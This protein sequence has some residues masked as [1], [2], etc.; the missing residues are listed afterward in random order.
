MSRNKTGNPIGSSAFL[1]FEDNVKNL[2]VA[3]NSTD[4]LWV[5]RFGNERLTLNEYDRLLRD[6]LA[7]AGYVYIGDY[8]GGIEITN[9]NQVIRDSDGNFWKAAGSTELPYTTTGDGIPEGGAL[10]Y[11]SE[12]FDRVQ[13]VA[14]IADLIAVDNPKSAQQY[15]VAGWWIGSNRGGG[16]FIWRPSFNKSLHNGGSVISPTVP[17]VTGQAGA[18]TSDKLAAYIAGTGEMDPAGTGCF[19]RQSKRRYRLEDFGHQ[20]GQDA[21]VALAGVVKSGNKMVGLFAG[22]YLF[23][24]TTLTSAYASLDIQG[25]GDGVAYA[26][27]TRLLP[28]EEGQSHLFSPEGG[29]N[30][31]KFSKLHF[32]GLDDCDFGVYQTEG[33]GWIFEDVSGNDFLDTCLYSEQGLNRYERCFIRGGEGRAVVAYS[34][35]A[36]DMCEFAGGTV[37]L[38]ITAG[39]GRIGKIWLN[40]GTEA[41]LDIYPRTSGTTHIN[42]SIESL[43]TG[44]TFAGAST[45]PII[46]VTGLA[47]QKVRQIQISNLHIVCAQANIDHIN[48]MIVGE[49]A[50][51]VTISNVAALGFGDFGN[52]NKYADGFLH[53][54][55]CLDWT[56]AGGV[57]ADINKHPVRLTRSNVSFGDTLVFKDWGDPLAT[58][59][60]KVCIQSDADSRVR[61]GDTQFTS[62]RIPDGIAGKSPSANRWRIGKVGLNISG[63]ANFVFADSLGSWEAHVGS[64]PATFIR[65]RHVTQYGQFSSLAGGGATAMFTLA[66]VAVDQSY[67]IT[68]QQVGNAANGTS[69][70][71]FASGATAGVSTTGNTNST[72]AL[73]NTFSLSGLGVRLDVGTGYGATTWAYQITRML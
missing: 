22:D 16:I 47:A 57:V 21:S 66:N 53:L 60:E 26:A 52:A 15:P 71:L 1:D 12:L 20:T 73:Q 34:D 5:D 44:E 54:T 48:T 69:G 9:Y 37:P 28:F 33:A 58:G 38:T 62:N 18:T 6:A 46:R 39:G 24:P 30:A 8:S 49:Y 72:A 29:C 40:S 51:D 7:S 68:V 10:V 19:V 23:S 61:I 64:D 59:D 63:G 27:I 13:S 50:D 35:F 42:T 45:A 2:D 25:C 65:G 70:V 17:F 31:V 32:N 4:P 56:I 41:C 43:Y 14:T 11:S 67:H 36:M 3:V 55:D